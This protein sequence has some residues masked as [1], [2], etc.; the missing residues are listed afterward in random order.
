MPTTISNRDHVL[1]FGPLLEARR[2]VDNTTPLIPSEV[3]S[4]PC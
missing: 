4:R 3:V 2:L 1:F